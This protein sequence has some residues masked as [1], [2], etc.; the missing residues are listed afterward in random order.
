MLLDSDKSE[1][2]RRIV[3][4]GAVPTAGRRTAATNG[5]DIETAPRDV[6]HVRGTPHTTRLYCIIQYNLTVYSVRASPVDQ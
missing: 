2:T 6:R 1:E 4:G 3:C 5:G